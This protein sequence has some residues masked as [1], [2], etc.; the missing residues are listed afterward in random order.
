LIE[1]SEKSN[2][3]RDLGIIESNNYKATLFVNR[4]KRILACTSLGSISGGNP[5][6]GAPPDRKTVE[7]YLEEISEYYQGSLCVEYSN[8]WRSIF[9]L[10]VI[11]HETTRANNYFTEI[12]AEIKKLSFSHLGENEISR[13]RDKSLLKRLQH[14]MKEHLSISISLATSLDF[15][16]AKKGKQRNLAKI[17][18]NTN[19]LNHHLISVPLLNYTEV[20]DEIESLVRFDITKKY[21]L[22]DKYRFSKSKINMSPRYIHLHELYIYTFLYKQG[23]LKPLNEQDVNNKIYQH[24][25]ECN[26]LQPNLPAPIEKE[27]LHALPE[28]NVSLLEIHIPSFRKKL[29]RIAIVNTN[30][31]EAECFACLDRPDLGTLMERRTRLFKILN[32]AREEKASYVVFPEFYLPIMWAK[33]VASF[34]KESGVGVISGIQ[35]VTFGNYTHNNV[36]VFQPSRTHYGFVNCIPLFREKN[37]YAPAERLE[38]SK[39]GYRSKDQTTPLYHLIVTEDTQYSTVLCFEF[40]DINTRASLK[41]KIDT[42]YVPQFNRDTNYFSS[43]VESASRDLHC[44]VMQANTSM[45]GDSRITAPYKTYKKDIIQ[46][47]GGINDSIIVGEVDIRELV[48]YRTKYI[49]SLERCID[50][51]SVCKKYR[52]A[53][54]NSD[55]CKKCENQLPIGHIKNVPPNFA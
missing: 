19:Y 32:A 53:N 44:F 14:D 8:M 24:F 40:T 49:T 37:Y 31:T 2:K 48:Q 42:L 36:V 13:N 1:N 46:V 5:R 43:I 30:I 15:S 54:C 9:E 22:K 45:Y 47:K 20:S 17:F 55:I 6:N 16:M 21:P 3:I 25:I 38:I 29:H 4:L 28:H 52:N 18:R 39:R 50:A 23:N 10:Y 34:S 35:Y 11:T 51:C 27:I 12:Y 26:N 7:K 33:D 41:A